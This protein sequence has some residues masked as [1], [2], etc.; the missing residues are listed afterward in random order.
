[1]ISD[2]NYFVNKSKKKPSASAYREELQ[3]QLWNISIKM[4][5]YQKILDKIPDQFLNK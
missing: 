5:R 1:M 4:I 3:D 2:G